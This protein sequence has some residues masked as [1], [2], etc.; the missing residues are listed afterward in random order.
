M[1]QTYATGTIFH[2]IARIWHKSKMT[3]VSLIAATLNMA[4]LVKGFR[5]GSGLMKSL[6][7]FPS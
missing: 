3:F 1:V 7:K 2:P 5:L 4:G 6:D